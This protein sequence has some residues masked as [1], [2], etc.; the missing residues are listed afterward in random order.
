MQEKSRR[1]KLFMQ[2]GFAALAGVKIGITLRNQRWKSEECVVGDMG[3]ARCRNNPQSHQSV[4]RFLN[5]RTVDLLDYVILCYEG[6][7]GYYR[8][9]SSIPNLYQLDARKPPPLELCQPNVPWGVKWPPA[10]NHCGGVK[11][12]KGNSRELHAMT[13]SLGF[14]LPIR[15]NH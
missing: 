1:R 3:M 4:A 7:L 13:R 5:F 10:E 2:Q 11:V 6:C 15:G 9:C 8:M 12:H 14:I